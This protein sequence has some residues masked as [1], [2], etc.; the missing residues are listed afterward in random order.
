MLQLGYK[1]CSMNIYFFNLLN[2]FIIETHTVT[3]TGVAKEVRKDAKAWTEI[4][5]H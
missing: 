4:T 3:Q 2:V 5:L 1:K